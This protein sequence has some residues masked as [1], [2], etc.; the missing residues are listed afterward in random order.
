MSSSDYYPE[1][2]QKMEEWRKSGCQLGWLINLK[3]EEVCIYHADGSV[4][5]HDNFERAIKGEGLIS[6]FELELS[7]L[8]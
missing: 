3:N 1:A 2:K 6:D 7:A 4:S 5:V 8:L